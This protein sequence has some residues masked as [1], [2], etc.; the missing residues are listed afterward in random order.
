VVKRKIKMIT[1]T[2]LVTR[3]QI[4]KLETKN[5][6]HKKKILVVDDHP[7]TR[8]G[9]AKIID[10]E[11]D[12]EI[13]AEAEDS[14]Q[15][16]DAIKRLKPDLVIADITL[17]DSSGLEL[18]KTIKKD[19]PALPVLIQ[20]MHE[21]TMYSERALQAGAMGYVMKDASTEELMAAIR[22]VLAGQV[23]TSEKMATRLVNKIIH[24]KAGRSTSPIDSLSDR[25][26]E[27]FNLLGKGFG[28]SQIAEKLKLSI[29]TVETYRAHLKEKLALTDA[30]ELRQYAIQWLA[31]RNE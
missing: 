19:Y 8:R 21:E 30:N 23:Y 12:L 25:E 26:L 2:K 1:K 5:E 13:V 28:T 14:T 4:P 31:S 3:E 22:K 7:V 20:S 11:S 24:G 17:K 10:Q 18:T 9:L 16:L 6:T 15:A 27:V 29:K